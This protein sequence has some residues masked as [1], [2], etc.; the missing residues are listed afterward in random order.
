MLNKYFE[1]VDVLTAKN[2]KHKDNFYLRLKELLLCVINR[3]L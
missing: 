2:R 3:I 1:S